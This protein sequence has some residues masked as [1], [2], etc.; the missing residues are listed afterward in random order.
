MNNELFPLKAPSDLQ[1]RG[2]RLGFLGVG[3]I[4]QSRLEVLKNQ[5]IAQIAAIADPNRQAAL[6]A[7]KIAPEA[8]LFDTL[9]DMAD[10]C[11]LD[12]LVIATPSAYHAPQA[13]WALERGLAV[14]CQKPLGANAMETRR[15]IDT[16]SR[17]DRLLGVD[18]SYRHLTGMREIRRRVQNRDIGDVFAVELV[19]HNAYG[20]D[21]AW[22][23][24]P[25]ES[26]GG[27][28]MDLGIHLVD[29]MLWVMDYPAIASVSGRVLSGGST[30]SRH[31]DRVEDY[32]TARIDF[33]NQATASLACSWN[34][35]AGCDAVIRAAFYGSKGALCLSNRDGSFFDFQTRH[36]EKTSRK[37]IAEDSRQ[38]WWGQSAVDWTLRLEKDRRYDPDM[39]KMIQ[40]AKILEAV[41]N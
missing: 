35:S 24:D 25:A 23:Y 40:V 8:R 22:Y 29:L 39:D 31:G 32:A 15:I 1:N 13:I 30:V 38:T 5:G 16:A 28:V 7:S 17:S 37:I 36:F 41:Y 4:G 33:E 6:A 19:F 21:K 18:L 11:D 12:A 26:G 34:L 10:Q 9:E 3:W 20:P 14:Y 27:C 2:P